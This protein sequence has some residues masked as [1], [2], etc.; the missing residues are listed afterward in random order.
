VIEVH[1]SVMAAFS[2][3]G[4]VCRAYGHLLAAGAGSLLCVP[5]VLSAGDLRTVVDCCPVP[6]EEV[7]AV[8]DAPPGPD[9]VPVEPVAFR[10]A[11]PSLASLAVEG[12]VLDRVSPFSA[13]RAE[14]LR[15]VHVSGIRF[16]KV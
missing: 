10:Q 3:D 9:P 4:R 5:M 15:L 2:A 8:L 6:W 14:A 1:V 11:W 16:A 7:W 13:G 12:W